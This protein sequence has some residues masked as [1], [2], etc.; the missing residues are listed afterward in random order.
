[1]SK[2]A[3]SH[4]FL[5]LANVIVRVEM[6]LFVGVPWPRPSQRNIHSLQSGSR[7]QS[8]SHLRDT[9]ETRESH[10]ARDS[11]LLSGY[12]TSTTGTARSSRGSSTSSTDS[13]TSWSSNT[14]SQH[15]HHE[16]HQDTG[17]VRHSLAGMSCAYAY[18]NHIL[19]HVIFLCVS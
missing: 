13:L 3:I 6:S 15:S 18:L 17:Q 10:A 4:Y 12:D 2:T 7:H 8:A 9:R 14:H 5:F 1:M 16:K 19:V 11:G